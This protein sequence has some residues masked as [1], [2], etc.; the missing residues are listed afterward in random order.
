MWTHSHWTSMP[1]CAYIHTSLVWYAYPPRL[2]LLLLLLEMFCSFHHHVLIVHTLHNQMYTI[3]CV[4]YC[5]VIPS[6]RNLF[7]KSNLIPLHHSLNKIGINFSHAIWRYGFRS[8]HNNIE[9]KFL[10]HFY[11]P[12]ATSFLFG[13]KL[14]IFKSFR[15]YYKWDAG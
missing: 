4:Y 11:W 15:Q 9:K 8:K 3:C 13:I 2:W 14:F 6:T 1:W 10:L 12:E 5:S 7:G